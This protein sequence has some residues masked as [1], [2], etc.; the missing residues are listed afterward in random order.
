MVWLPAFLAA[1]YALNQK[2]NKDDDLLKGEHHVLTGQTVLFGFNEEKP[3]AG[4]NQSLV[5]CH[6]MHFG[7]LKTKDV[8]NT[9]LI[10]NV[11]P[12]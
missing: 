1:R 5:K 6:I 8:S 4:E 2:K 10:Y 12:P 9:I 11:G 3:W 7:L